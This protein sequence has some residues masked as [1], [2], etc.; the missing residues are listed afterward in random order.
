[1]SN[2][3]WIKKLKPGDKVIIKC[4][5]NSQIATVEKITSA[6]NIKAGGVLFNKLGVERSS[7]T[8]Y[9]SKFFLAEATPDAIKQ[10]EDEQ[11]IQKAKRLVNKNVISV[12]KAKVIISMLESSNNVIEAPNDEIKALSD[13]IFSISNSAEVEPVFQSKDGTEVTISKELSEVLNAIL[14]QAFIPYIAKA[15][16]EAGYVKSSSQATET[17]ALQEEITVYNIQM[18]AIKHFSED[19]KKNIDD[20]INEY[21]NGDGGGYYLAED[22]KPDIDILVSDYENKYKTKKDEI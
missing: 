1:M 20:S 6:G 4:M 17:K 15:L 8:Y 3:E 19:L 12:E 7:D 13:F 18:D 22:V 11:L 5:D 21:W 2:N 10:C 9:F 16:Y 14:E